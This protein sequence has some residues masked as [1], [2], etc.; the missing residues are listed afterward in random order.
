MKPRLAVCQWSDPTPS[1][2]PVGEPS[3][4]QDLDV[5][6]SH[7]EMTDAGWGKDCDSSSGILR[8]RERGRFWAMSK[9]RFQKLP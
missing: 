6:H 4:I 2:L 5:R 7:W 3:V 8:E 1:Q 9:T